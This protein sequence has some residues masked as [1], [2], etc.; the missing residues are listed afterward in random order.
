[1]SFAR[2]HVPHGYARNFGNWE[3]NW[4]MLFDHYS[5]LMFKFQYGD[6]TFDKG[7]KGK[8]LQILSILLGNFAKANAR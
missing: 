8:L 3:R 7:Q 2:P 5:V 4:C 1:M 6:F